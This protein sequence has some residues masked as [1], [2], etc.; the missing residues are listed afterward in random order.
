VAILFLACLDHFWNAHNPT[1]PCQLTICVDRNQARRALG[2][3]TSSQA[4]MKHISVAAVLEL[5]QSVFA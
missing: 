1:T 4:S 2:L 5:D 3:C